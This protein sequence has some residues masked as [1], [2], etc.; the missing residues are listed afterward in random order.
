MNKLFE[1]VPR[2]LTDP[3]IGSYWTVNVTAH[4][5]K[6][7]RKRKNR[8]AKEQAME[9]AIAEQQQ[10]QQQQQAQQ[11]AHHPPEGPTGPIPPPPPHHFDPSIGFPHPHP[12]P[13]VHAHPHSVPGG[14]HFMQGPPQGLHP[15]FAVGPT[16]HDLDD[17]S[18][19]DPSL[20][21]ALAGP[22]DAKVT[23]MGLRQELD[24]TKNQ[25]ALASQQA[26]KLAEQ[27]AA[28]EE[29]IRK[30]RVEVDLMNVKLQTEILGRMNLERKYQEL[31]QDRALLDEKVKVLTETTESGVVVVRN[32]NDQDVDA[33]G[34]A[35][36]ETDLM[37]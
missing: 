2:P 8:Q 35:E 17:G 19:I 28:A 37:S 9:N 18:L 10:Q 26:S 31:E 22:D 23:I 36:V 20:D 3:G 11:H 34:D 13:H 6:R 15:G 30:C 25:Y 14:H 21:P 1:K 7:P 12:H 24:E 29:E 5:A 27:L 4:G 16:K 33:E 32:G